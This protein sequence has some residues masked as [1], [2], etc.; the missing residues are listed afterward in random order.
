MKQN[1]ELTANYMNLISG[2]L[3]SQLVEQTKN[4]MITMTDKAMNEMITM[5]DK[6]RNEMLAS[7]QRAKEKLFENM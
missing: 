1:I 7:A 6:T 3:N 5:A 2:S 4:E